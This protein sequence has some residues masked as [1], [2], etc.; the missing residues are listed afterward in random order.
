[1]YLIGI[2]IDEL[3]EDFGSMVYT[4]DNKISPARLEAEFPKWK[5]QAI[6][7]VYNGTRTSKSN[8]FINGFNFVK[9]RSVYSIGNQIIGASFVRFKIEPAIQ[10]DNYYN[11]F[12]F[13]G[14]ELTSK[15]FMQFASPNS[16]WID[17][18]SNLITVNDV[19]FFSSGYDLDIY[20][21]IQVR[22][23]FFNYIPYDVMNVEI[24]DE[25]TKSYRLFNP[26][27]DKYPISGDVWAIMKQL[28]MAE[29]TPPNLRPADMT[30][31]RSTPL[32]KQ[33]NS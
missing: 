12:T 5:Q 24:Y 15:P 17:K 18:E 31:D 4:E 23:V 16:Y 20:G 7:M 21:N 11:G 19:C 13:V 14:D 6:Q 3:M 32:E 22:Q 30:L 29:L 27:T 9:T 28:A 2:Y 26:E 1:M 8:K 10:I 33:A 25:T